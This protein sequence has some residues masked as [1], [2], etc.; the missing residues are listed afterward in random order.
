MGKYKNRWHE[1]IVLWT[2]ATVL[3]VLNVML[4]RSFF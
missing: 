2:I 4:F 3:T 1:N